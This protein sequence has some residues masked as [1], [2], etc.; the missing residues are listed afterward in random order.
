MVFS[1]SVLTLLLYSI[2]IVF[3]SCCLLC[4]VFNSTLFCYLN[5]I[6]L[7]CADF[8]IKIN[9]VGVVEYKCLMY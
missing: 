9:F 8:S 7:I 2:F 6:Q 5:L 1:F 4:Y 3:R